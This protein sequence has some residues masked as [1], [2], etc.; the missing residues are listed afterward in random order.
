LNVGLAP[1]ALGLNPLSI[2][3]IDSDGLS[4]S[5]LDYFFTRHGFQVQIARDGREAQSLIQTSE[6]PPSVVLLELMLP[7]VDGYELLRLIRKS[8]TW[9]DVAILV[10]SSKTQEDDIVRAFKSGASDYVVKPFRPREL[11]A[12]IERLIQ[13]E[14][15]R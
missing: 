12:R 5:L 11:M 3:L 4:V 10:L 15:S 6:N 2:L 1:A 14:P 7:Y 8:E 13:P 9:K